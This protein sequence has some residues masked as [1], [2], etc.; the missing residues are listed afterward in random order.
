MSQ[1]RWSARGVAAPLSGFLR[2]EVASASVLLVA[3]LVALLWANVAPDSYEAA[4]HTELALR[5]GDHALAMDLREW[6]NSGL[7]TLFFLVVG[8]EARREFDLGELRDRKRFVLPLLAGVLAMALPVTVYLAINHGGPGAGGWGVAMSTDTALALGF[9]SFV[10]AGVS[11]RVRVFLV[12]VFVVDDLVALLVIAI[13]YSDAIDPM[14]IA[15]AVVVFALFV[16]TL[17]IGVDRPLVYALMGV[18]IWAALLESGVD[19]VVAGLV[20]GLAG[21]AYTP[22]RDTLELASGLFRRFREEPTAEFARTASVGL[23]AALSPNAR[24]QRF[25][26][27][28][29]SFLIVPLFGLANAGVP[30]SGDFLARAVTSPI[31]LGIVVAYVVGKPVAVIAATWGVSR[32][33]GGRI[34]PP[35]GWAAVAGSG[36][37]AG[38]AFT[39]SLLI[40]T[41]AFSGDELAEAKVG[42][43]TASLLA[44]L[45]TAVVFALTRRLPYERRARAL[46]GDA[47]QLVDLSVPVDPERDHVRGAVH[48]SVTLVEYGDFECPHC[49]AA[50]P[51]ARA[52]LADDQDLRFVWRHL[53]LSDVHPRAQLAAEASEAAGEQGRFWEMH[54]LLLDRQEH[55]TPR[56]LMAYAAELGLD[57]DRFGEDLFT[58]RYAERIDRD[59]VSADESGVSGTPTFFVNG[60]RHHGAFDVASLRKAVM[61]ARAQQGQLRS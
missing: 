58:H 4:W 19:P 29:T 34:R 51:A 36:T 30:L 15:V 11:D 54:D 52:E 1:T 21:S 17:R 48:A 26:V 49:G 22:S 42:V 24:L 43:L 16:L 55:L 40:A 37:I 23:T 39:V 61:V 28:W 33:S 18:V 60:R 25:Y 20:I 38:T 53:P 3:I 6:V 35:V 59:L 7:M 45:L 56:D 8:L 9:L 41:L 27:P 13:F 57:V 32:L 14:A 31:T 10:G 5:L 2:T 46:L 47:E 12:T 44:V 50:E